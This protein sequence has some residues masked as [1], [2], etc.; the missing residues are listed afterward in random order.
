MIFIGFSGTQPKDKE[1]QQVGQYLKFGLLGGVVLFAHNIE[2]RSQLS[3]LVQYFI[4]CCPEVMIGVDQEG[5]KVQ[6]LN[7]QNGFKCYPPAIEVGKE[8][9][10]DI[11]FSIYYEMAK[12]LADIGINLNYAPVLDLSHPELPG[13]PLQAS[14]RCFS[15]DI[16]TVTECARA[17]IA[18][19]NANDV[20]TVA[21]HYPGHGF[22]E[23]DTHQG[24]I[25]ITN[26]HHPDE[27]EPFDRM[28]SNNELHAVMTAH[29]MHQ[30]WDNKHPMTLSQPSCQ[31]L[32]QDFSGLIFSDDLH[33]SA[34]QK[35]YSLKEI[36]ELSI[37]AGIDALMFSNNPLAAKDNPHFERDITLPEKIHVVV[38]EAL[39]DGVLD[40]TV[41][42]A[43]ENRWKKVR[44]KRG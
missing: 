22:A 11:I 21:K 28:C 26:S 33:M 8:K 13:N 36:V 44:E 15:N 16:D 40:K 25:D 41:I 24:L 31:R 5:G 29:L 20:L 19:H 2:S 42:E 43:S 27:L 17:F 34:I 39:K 4:S 12:E 3:H 23:G 9:N 30:K 1:V 32:R 10:T 37:N 35:H 14:G 18:A 7:E 6:R 38:E